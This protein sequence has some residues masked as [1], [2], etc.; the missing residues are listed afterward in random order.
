VSLVQ[1]PVGFQ[2]VL[3][4]MEKKKY[5]SLKGIRTPNFNIE[6]ILNMYLFFVWAG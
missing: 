5:F 2:A 3:K 4:S 1:K 6:G